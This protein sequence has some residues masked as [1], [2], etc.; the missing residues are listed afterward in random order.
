MEYI[1]VDNPTKWVTKKRKRIITILAIAGTAKEFEKVG[2][3]NLPQDQIHWSVG[4]A[5]G[6]DHPLWG[7]NQGCASTL[8]GAKRDALDFLQ[9]S[10]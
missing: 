5:G 4:L 9:K 10:R 2:L 3:R 8:E 6:E 7:E 1:Y